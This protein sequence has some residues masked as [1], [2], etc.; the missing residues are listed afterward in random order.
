MKNKYKKQE[1]K[2]DTIY[3]YIYCFKV[4]NFSMRYESVHI[5]IH[6]SNYDLSLILFIFLPVQNVN[7]IYLEYISTFEGFCIP[8]LSILLYIVRLSQLVAEYR[9]PRPV[10][11]LWFIWSQI[12]VCQEPIIQ[13]NLLLF[14]NY[15]YFAVMKKI[16]KISKISSKRHLFR[17]IYFTTESHIIRHVLSLHSKL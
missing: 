1:Y 15:W 8:R 17:E 12:F 9:I 5:S 6:F 3:I 14:I 2:Q 10:F 13:S 4:L 7:V 11:N 16:S